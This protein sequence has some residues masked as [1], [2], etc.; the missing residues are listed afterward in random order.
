VVDLDPCGYQGLKVILGTLI[1]PRPFERRSMGMC[2]RLWAFVAPMQKLGLWLDRESGM[3]AITN[4]PYARFT[5]RGKSRPP[6]GTIDGCA[7][8]TRGKPKDGACSTEFSHIRAQLIH[9]R[10]G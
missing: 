7:E 3:N 8:A 5:Q 2:I 9:I 4:L 6:H 10:F 1:G